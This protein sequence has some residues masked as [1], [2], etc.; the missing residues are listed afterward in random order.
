MSSVTKLIKVFSGRVRIMGFLAVLLLLA[1]ACTPADVELIQGILQDVDSANGEITIVTKDGK[2]V[3]LTISTDATVETEGASSA[4]ETLEP[5][6]SIEVEV[7]DDGRV[8][9]HIRAHQAKL[10]GRIVGIEGN[11]VTIESRRG[12]TVM[13]LVTGV[14]R[15]ELEDDFR[16]TLSDLRV[17]SEVEVKFDPDSRVAFK[18]DFDEEEAE[19]EGVVVALA[20]NEVTV[21]TE[22]GRR[23]TLIVGERTRIE[24]EDDFPG[25]LA[26][27]QVG[28]AI[29]AKFDP[30]T[31]DALKIEVEDEEAEI[32]GIVVEVVGNE[33]TIETQRGRRV[34]LLIGERTKVELDDDFPGTA[35]DIEVGTVLKAKFDPVT[36]TAFK[37]EVEEEHEENEDEDNG[38][39]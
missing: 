23:L 16:G 7:N 8:A 20:G 38:R 31:R 36:G 28:A 29:E 35:E 39:S 11:E 19:I 21:E 2:T 14:T 32:K 22:R 37:V 5:G 6:A 24:F 10:Q 1:L 25:S 17:G 4:I 15:I 18:I 9:H 3:T 30:F 34:K 33:V 13:V 27:L 26:D 12:R